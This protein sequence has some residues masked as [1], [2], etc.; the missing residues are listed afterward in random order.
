[1]MDEET[2][3]DEEK[4]IKNLTLKLKDEVTEFLKEEDKNYFTLKNK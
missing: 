1:M 4:R 3:E 2:R